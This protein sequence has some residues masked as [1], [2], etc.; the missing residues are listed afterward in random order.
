MN[1]L[2]NVRKRIQNRRFDKPKEHTLFFTLFFRAMMLVMGAAVLVLA[3]VINVKVGLVELPADIKNIN[4][5][6][7]SEWLPF[8]SWFQKEDQ[9]VDAPVSYSLLKDNEYTNGSN[10]V[11]LLL[12]GVVLHVQ[13]EGAN[14]GSVTVRHDNGVIATY[15]H[16]DT[17]SVKQDERILKDSVIGAFTDYVTID[18]LKNNQTIDMATALAS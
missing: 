4:F 10:Q 5:G 1:E 11:H 2:H 14:R 17:I 15:G 7:V 3:Y 9:R 12:D 6:L 16:M 13:K 8:E 18:L